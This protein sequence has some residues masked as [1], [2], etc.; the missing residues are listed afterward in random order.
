MRVSIV[1]LTRSP[2]LRPENRRKGG[3]LGHK[4]AVKLPL[5]LI[6]TCIEKQLGVFGAK[7][8]F[9]Y[10]NFPSILPEFAVENFL[11]YT[12]LKKSKS[13]EKYEK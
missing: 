5:F 3:I 2:I 6:S 4:S 7:K 9:F 11:E 12:V 8:A 13:M 10:T 1:C